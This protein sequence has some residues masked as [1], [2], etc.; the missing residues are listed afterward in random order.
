MY[1][2][3]QHASKGAGHFKY[4]CFYALGISAVVCLFLFVEDFMGA[5]SRSAKTIIQAFV[6]LFLL[7]VITDVVL[8]ILSAVKLLQMARTLTV[9]DHKWFDEQKNR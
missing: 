3:P 1:R 2:N 4:Y 7:T 5:P 6:I 8:L 9:S